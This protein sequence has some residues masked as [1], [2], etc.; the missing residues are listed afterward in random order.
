[1]CRHNHCAYLQDNS[2]PDQVKHSKDDIFVVV[3]PVKQVVG[4][5]DESHRQQGKR[6]VLQEAKV[7]GLTLTIVVSDVIWG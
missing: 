4:N 2:A 1:M 3:L 7:E 6:K 5:S